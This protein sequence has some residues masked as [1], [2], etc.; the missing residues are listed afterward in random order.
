ML[1][2]AWYKFTVFNYKVGVHT[3]SSLSAL[4]GLTLSTSW[5]LRRYS[6]LKYLLGSQGPQEVLKL[7]VPPGVSGGTLGFLF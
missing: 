3:N 4:Q 1:T 2:D 7:E 5:G 6:N